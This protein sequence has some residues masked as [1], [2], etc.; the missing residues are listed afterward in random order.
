MGNVLGAHSG[1]WAGAKRQQRKGSRNQRAVVIIKCSDDYSIVTS[2]TL[3][4]LALLAY[5]LK[6]SRW[7]IN[8]A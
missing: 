7:P 6:F 3:P 2:T 1:K 4:I 8:L 5:V